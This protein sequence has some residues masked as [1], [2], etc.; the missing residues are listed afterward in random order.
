MAAFTA[1]GT[2]QLS[3]A[4]GLRRYGRELGGAGAAQ[5]GVLVLQVANNDRLAAITGGG[6]VATKTASYAPAAALA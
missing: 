1:A 5:P 6:T 3:W 2:L 4:K